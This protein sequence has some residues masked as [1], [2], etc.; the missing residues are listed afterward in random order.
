MIDCGENV[1][2]FRRKK[3]F[4]ATPCNLNGK[5]SL[6]NLQKLIR[7]NIFFPF[8]LKYVAELCIYYM[9]LLPFTK[10]V[11]LYHA[12]HEIE[13]FLG[14]QKRTSHFIVHFKTIDSNFIIIYLTIFTFLKLNATRCTSLTDKITLKPSMCI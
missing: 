1:F 4:E 14:S 7:R 10:R 3:K 11:V 2:C 12:M 9:I 8:H 5:F 6:A 13:F